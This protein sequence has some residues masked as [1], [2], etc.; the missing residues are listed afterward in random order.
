MNRKK[1][2]GC[3]GHPP[4]RRDVCWGSIA[5]QSHRGRSRPPSGVRPLGK[6]PGIGDQSSSHRYKR[7]RVADPYPY[8]VHF[9]EEENGASPV[10][11]WIL[12]DLTSAERRAVTAALRELVGAMGQNVCSTEFGKNLGGG[13][14]ELRLRQNEDQILKRVG[15]PPT[16][17][18][19]EDDSEDILLR[20]FFHPHGD[21]QALVLH[22]YSKG[23]N[24]SK[25]HQQE[26]IAIAEGRLSR[27]KEREKKRL[28]AEKRK[29]GK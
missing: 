18:H 21:K 24:S 17:A 7:L 29:G 11:N 22:G 15:Q 27:W 16:Q 20:V 14:I 3:S 8:N 10:L 9:Y 12:N 6:G 5:R 13:L 28:K 23:K 4:Y 19:P 1:S 2:C 26:Q 25:S